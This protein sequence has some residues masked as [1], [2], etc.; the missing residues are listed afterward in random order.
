LT[1]VEPERRQWGWINFVAFWIADSLNVVS[2]LCLTEHSYTK[3]KICCFFVFSLQCKG[4]ISLTLLG[5]N[6]WMISSSMIVDG[7]SWWQAWLCVWIGYTISAIFVYLIGRIG[8]VYRIPFA[9]SNRASFGIWGSFWPV[10][11]RAAMAVIWY[12]VQV[13]DTAIC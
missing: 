2:V 6:T 3:D 11:N 5:Q 4:S 7:L 1:A 10:M 8:S 9:V 12:G 13:S